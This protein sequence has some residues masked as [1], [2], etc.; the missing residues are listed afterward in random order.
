MTN[1]WNCLR[2][3]ILAELIV[4]L[5]GL[6]AD[7]AGLRC[8]FPQSIFLPQ[9]ALPSLHGRYEGICV[10]LAVEHRVGL[11]VADSCQ[12]MYNTTAV[13]SKL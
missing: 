12:S 10:Q 1:F 7:F 11:G 2:E 4:K 5:G 9:M 13:L 3:D 8:F 6:D